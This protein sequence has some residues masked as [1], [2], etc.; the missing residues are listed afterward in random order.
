MRRSIAPAAMAAALFPA[1]MVLFN[2][3]A[4]A[5]TT[6]W[7]AVAQCETGGNWSAD[8]GN[9][10]AGGLQFTPET[11]ATH[12]G[13]GS[14]ANASRADQIQVARNVAA[15]QGLNAWPRCG[16]AGGYGGQTFSG[17][18]FPAARATPPLVAIVSTVTQFISL[19]TPQG[20]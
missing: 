6:D 1:L 3:T 18:P 4:N 5:D 11:W 10:F 15:T 20:R 12:G 17:P 7:D 19:F 13:I 8:T 16:S 14:P 2:G 9:G